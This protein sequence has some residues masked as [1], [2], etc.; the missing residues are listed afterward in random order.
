MSTI[1]GA[2]TA[3]RGSN[4]VWAELSGSQGRGAPGERGGE[5]KG[6]GA[7]AA[8]S[9]PEHWE[10]AR[11]PVLGEAEFAA[12]QEELG[13]H[14]IEH[15]GRHWSEAGRGF[16]QPVH[17]LARLR[18][19]EATRPTFRCWGF[20]ARLAAEDEPH[21]DASI[22]VHVLPDPQSY[23]LQRL[24]KRRR[25]SIRASMRDID[26]VVLASPDILIDQGYR[27][28]E[29]AHANNPNAVLPAPG[30]F[31]RKVESYFVPGR[32]LAL[33][34][35]QHDRLLGFSLIH[36]VDGVAYDHSG[37][38][39]RDG[40]E[41]NVPA[42]LFHVVASIAQQS[43]GIGELMNGLHSRE[44]E[45]LCAFKQS[46]GCE[47]AQ[48]P[49]RAWFAPLVEPVLRRMRPHKHYRLAGLERSGVAGTEPAAD[50]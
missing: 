24:S 28:A 46:Q 39:G 2:A 9:A 11:F 14:V 3:L 47:V 36:A 30:G 44:A 12:W 10:E 22:P 31:R 19:D 40:L 48:L 37:S 7:N 29:E 49:A 38:I 17:P 35:L 13:H 8:S 4:G 23:S 1:S 15:R 25:Q 45:S 18:R 16:F 5:A 32:G 27:L 41:R 42:C 21:A 26:V 43:A 50:S 34:A 6:I 33:A 20:R